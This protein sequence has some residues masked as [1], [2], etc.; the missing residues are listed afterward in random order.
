MQPQQPQDQPPE[1]WRTPAQA[2]PQ[3]PIEVIQNEPASWEQPAAMPTAPQSAEQVYVAPDETND[4]EDSDDGTIEEMAES[5]D[6]GAVIRWQAV[7]YLHQ[8]QSPLWF[9]VMGII[10]MV[11]MAIAYLWMSSITFVILIPVMAVALVVYVKRPPA[12]N[13]YTLSRKGLHINDQLYPFDTF[14]SFGVVSRGGNHSV[15]L[16]PRKRFQL[17]HTV[18]FNEELGEQIVDMFASR[19][20]MKDVSPDMIDTLLS[21]L[22]L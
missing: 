16:T 14:K 11:L 15:V 13:N 6:D 4:R 3:A 7:E 9:V 8:D 21:K 20:P 17:G 10:V 22:R 1:T 12:T 19:L 2:A 5:P 18:Y